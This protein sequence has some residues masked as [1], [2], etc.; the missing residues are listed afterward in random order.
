MLG[1]KKKGKDTARETSRH[2]ISPQQINHEAVGGRRPSSFV[3]A[4]NSAL[5]KGGI[6]GLYRTVEGSAMGRYFRLFVADYELTENRLISGW[7]A[8]TFSRD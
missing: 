7:L 5:R 6:T 2:C 8:R 3:T 1:R 4:V